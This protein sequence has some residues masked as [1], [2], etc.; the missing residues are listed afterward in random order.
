MHPTFSN[1]NQSFPLPN[2]VLTP[3]AFDILPIN[4]P[5]F[6]ITTQDQTPPKSQS[7]SKNTT[8]ND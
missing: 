6:Q 4:N 3:L 2:T 5:T 7:L 1:Q 8:M